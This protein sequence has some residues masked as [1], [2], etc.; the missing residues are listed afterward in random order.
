M[1]I[2]AVAGAAAASAAAQPAKRPIVLD[3]L[4]RL[5]EVD[6]PQRSPDGGWV[7]YTV[8]SHDVEKD[9]RNTDIWM[10]RW[11]GNGEIR[12]TSSPE[13]ETTPRWSPDGKYLAFLASRGD[14]DE[15]KKGDQ[16]W[17]LRRAGGEA[18]KLTDI[19]G[20]VSD[21]AWSPDSARLA[22][23][24]GE[25]DPDE[26]PEK[27]EGWARKTKPPI[28]IDRYHFKQDREGYLK[29][30]YEH[31]AIFELA[32]KSL[33]PLTSGAVDDSDPAWS[34]DG[35][36]IAFRSKRGHAEPDRTENSDLFAIEARA[37]AQP[38]QLTTTR[39]GEVGTPEWSPDGS[40]IAVLV[41]D[42][43]RFY[44]Y[45]LAKLALV[46]AEGG[47][48]TLLTG[49]LDRPVSD[50]AWEADGRS[51]IFAVEDDRASYIGRVSAAGGAVEAVTEGRRVVTAP[52][53]GADGGIAVLASTPGQP[54]E[55]FALEKGGLRALS[56]QNDALRDQLEL[57][58]VT[59]FS[60]KSRDGTIVHGLL[61][62]PAGSVEG[63]KLPTLLFIHGGPNGQDDYA[64]R[65]ERELFAARGYAVLE[66]N[67]RGSSGR[68]AAFQRAI[69]A[70][71]GDKEVQDLLGAVDEAVRA[72]VADPDRLGIGGWSY[73]GILTNY[74]IATD[75]RF[76][77]AV[78]GASSS[79]QTTMYGLDQYIVQYD[80][81]M[82][83]P[84]KKK[85]LWTRVSY[86]FYRADKIRT[87]TL[88]LC[89]QDD[90]NVPVAG[91]EQMYQAL[92]SLGLDTGL[93]IY[94]GQ[95]H[96]LTTP[97]YQRDRMERYLAWWG[98][99]LH[100]EPPRPGVPAG[101]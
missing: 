96:G 11:D 49:A 98:K 39:E 84:W 16:V 81:E 86:P 73:G 9:K 58:T 17:L 68:G 27:K 95:Y 43:D 74:T 94:P 80:S 85:D 55:I 64:F 44:A 101:E 79:L 82:G 1:W 47:A 38:R 5:R 92:R 18:E 91:V 66:I 46:P 29:G 60:S 2:A 24:V 22:L 83:Q 69:Y 25:F 67:Y 31:L 36:T 59:D 3:D 99:Y 53:P 78:S 23:V 13:N 6:D 100:P 7:A 21:L 34:P 33:V 65:F 32:S 42:E 71:W 87:P 26:D 57:A 4:S 20:G 10:A 61:T 30:L 45:D 12:L 14:E 56:H 50:P 77:A 75:A 37:G 41:A 15:K 88:F 35:R 40:R 62:R 93:V 28:V 76:K 72:G 63:R 70:N 90:F 8:R 48:P 97:S 89:G 51:L 52:S 54:I 19:K